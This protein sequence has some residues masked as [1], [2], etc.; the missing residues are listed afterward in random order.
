M[1]TMALTVTAIPTELSQALVGLQDQGARL[2]YTW[3]IKA[4]M[5]VA[6]AAGAE[7]R[8]DK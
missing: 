1:Y 3:T 7:P 5:A 6:A 4:V 8:H 2:D